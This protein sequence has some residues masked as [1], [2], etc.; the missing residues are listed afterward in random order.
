MKH[1]AKYLRSK[2]LA[3]LLINSLKCITDIKC[4]DKWAKGNQK[5]FILEIQTIATMI[6][7]LTVTKF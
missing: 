2:H 7:Y 5:T 3:I 4:L 1:L 6:Y